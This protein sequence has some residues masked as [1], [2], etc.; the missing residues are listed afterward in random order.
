MNE[1]SRDTDDCNSNAMCINTDGSFTCTCASG[2]SGNGTNCTGKER[3]KWLILTQINQTVFIC[4]NRYGWLIPW[5]NICVFF[6]LDINECFEGINDCHEYANC[7]NSDGSYTCACN[8]GYIGN[9]S[10]CGG[11]F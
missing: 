7:T 1:C 2:Y 10:T 5:D 8:T 4:K 6:C 9:G 11:N 3:K